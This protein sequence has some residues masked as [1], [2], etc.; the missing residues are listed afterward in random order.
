MHSTQDWPAIYRELYYYC[1]H[2]IIHPKVVLGLG[3][4]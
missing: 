3:R 2:P 1:K 4:V